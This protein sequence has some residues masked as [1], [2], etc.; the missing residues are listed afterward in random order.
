M[1]RGGTIERA[2]GRWREILV[3]FGVD[4]RYLVNRH[5][6]CP[7]CGG[8]DRFRFDDK[9]GSGSFYC[10]R[11]GPGAGLH[12]LRRLRNWNHATACREVDRFIGI[13]QAASAVAPGSNQECT[14]GR[15]ERIERLLA[16]A[17]EPAVVD[18]YLTRRGLSI[19]SPVLRGDT[20]CAYYD[21]NGGVLGHHPAVIAPVVG[22]DG[23]LRSAQ[24]IYDASVDPR[25][26]L[27]PAADTI[28]GAAVRL[29]DYTDVL[30]VAE[31]VETALAAHQL[32]DIPVWAALSA[33]GLKSFMPAP[34]VRLLHV[35]ADNDVNFVGQAAAYELAKRAG[36]S[37]VEVRV[38]V[39]PTA[40][41]DW[42]DVLLTGA[43]RA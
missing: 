19:S 33:E 17:K 6:P 31:G 42:L 39:P 32:Y 11:C 25:K 43:G 9:N 22:L 13:Y 8:R 29:Q 24:R 36:R 10:N 20:R 34:G 41:T 21:S 14:A 4:S 3:H 2:R 7:A 38:H 15:R 27:M 37:G 28:I 30:G 16:D 5:G 12:L 23:T 18:R 1:T 26:K 35:F 40:G